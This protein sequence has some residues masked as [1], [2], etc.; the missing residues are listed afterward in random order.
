MTDVAVAFVQHD[1]EINFKLGDRDINFGL[2]YHP[3]WVGRQI[4]EPEVVNCM[5]HFIKP[6]DCVIDA[7]ANLGFFTLLMS[8]LVGDQGLVV[9]FEPDP[10]C[11][12]TLRENIALNN[13]TNVY[14][15]HQL[16]WSHDCHVDFWLMEH[17]GYSSVIRYVNV[18]DP[19]PQQVMGRCLDSLLLEPHPTFMKIDCE[20]SEERILMGAEKILRKG[21]DGVVVELNF[22]IMPLVGSSEKSIR[23]YMH[24]LGYDF[25]LLPKDKKPIYI[26]PEQRI[27]IVAGRYKLLNVLFSKREKVDQL[28]MP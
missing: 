17:C 22:E 16:L 27:N 4:Y 25:F 7:G 6:G 13:V 2:T 14:S 20:G 24:G 1:H 8:R 5:G 21:V 10:E 15:V 3:S 11:C 19:K 28:W 9:A 12:K 18:S 26:E 23:D